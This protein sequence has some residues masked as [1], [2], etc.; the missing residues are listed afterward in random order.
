M[1]VSTDVG[2]FAESVAMVSSEALFAPSR[3]W[4][5]ASCTA[6]KRS[7]IGMSP[8]GTSSLARENALLPDDSVRV[9]MAIE[10][11]NDSTGAPSARW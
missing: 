8:V 11:R 9:L 6:A 4:L 7:T 5:S 2:R 1:R 3:A 10:V